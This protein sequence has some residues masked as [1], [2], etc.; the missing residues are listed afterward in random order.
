MFDSRFLGVQSRNRMKASACTF[1][2]CCSLASAEDDARDMVR[3]KTE[4]M[5]RNKGFGSLH[6]Q[7]CTTEDYSVGTQWLTPAKIAM[8]LRFAPAELAEAC[9][10]LIEKDEPFLL[11]ATDRLAAPASVFSCV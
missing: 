4:T 3:V 7:I 11:L 8:I 1:W 5:T 10:R 9:G 2:F 6:G